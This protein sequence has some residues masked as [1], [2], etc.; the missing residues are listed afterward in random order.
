MT[1]DLV[2]VAAAVLVGAGTQRIAGM[3][4]ASMASAVVLF[5]LWRSVEWSKA[6]LLIPASLVGIVPGCSEPRPAVRRL[7]RCPGS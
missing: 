1:I 7:V 5:Q 4:Y 2:L 6:V 3:E